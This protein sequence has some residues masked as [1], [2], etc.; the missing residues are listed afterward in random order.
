M[1]NLSLITAL[2]LLALVTGCATV[3]VIPPYPVHSDPAWVGNDCDIY[4]SQLKG[5]IAY[6]FNHEIEGS[7]QPLPHDRVVMQ[8]K[9]DRFNNLTDLT[10][11]QQSSAQWLNDAVRHAVKRQPSLPSWTE[12]ILQTVGNQEQFTLVYGPEGL[13]LMTDAT[14]H[15][16]AEDYHAYLKGLQDVKDR[17]LAE[18]AALREKEAQRRVEAEAKRMTYIRTRPEPFA[19]AMADHK[20]IIGMTSEDV[21]AAWGENYEVVLEHESSQGSVLQL[22]YPDGDSHSFLL[23]FRNNVLEDWTRFTR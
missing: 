18:E 20:I 7:T 9:V 21:K 3:E 14:P 16:A 8:F 22:R 1:R 4:L 23:T 10:Y 15:T 17:K 11:V 12:N 5:S 19:R 13:V 6:S 2:A